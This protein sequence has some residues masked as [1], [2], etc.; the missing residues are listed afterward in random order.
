RC[1]W[2]D[3]VA[4]GHAAWLNGFTTLAVTK[5]DVLDGM[6]EL[7][8]CTAYRLASGEVIDWVPD[9]PDMQDATPIYETWP[10]WSEPTTGVRAWDDLPK[11][12]RAYLHRISELAGVPIET[13]S[14]GA[15]REQLVTVL[16]GE[17]DAGRTAPR[18]A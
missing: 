5:L 3:A 10:G 1:G 16:P 2:Y 9:T 4:V 7:K 12:A 17:A 13:V 8:I 14:V 6:R 11:A 15:E 18:H